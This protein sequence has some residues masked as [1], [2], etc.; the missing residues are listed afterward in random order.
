M[1]KKRLVPDMRWILQKLEKFKTA[2]CHCFFKEVPYLRMYRVNSAHP[3][4]WSV[5]GPITKIRI[6]FHLKP[7]SVI[8]WYKIH[9]I[10]SH[11]F[12][13]ILICVIGLCTDHVSGCAVFTLYIFKN[14]TSLKLLWHGENW[15][16]T[17]TFCS[18]VKREN[19][20]KTV[21]SQF[22]HGQWFHFEKNTVLS[23]N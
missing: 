11:I 12:N 15:E 20:A 23:H 14:G 7:I 22:W 3:Q 5:H 1:Y 2:Q 9:S 8:E 4:T 18:P 10:S 16:V 19:G 6:Y 13:G 21:T 17:P